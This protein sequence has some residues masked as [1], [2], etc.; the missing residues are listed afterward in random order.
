MT[1]LSYNYY[2]T[3]IRHAAARWDLGRRGMD[4]RPVRL[5]TGPRRDRSPAASQRPSHLPEDAARGL[6]GGAPHSSADLHDQRRPLRRPCGRSTGC[7]RSWRGCAIRT[8]AVPGTWSRPSPPSRPTRSRKP[9]RSPTPSSADDLTDLKDE[10]GDLLLQV[11]FHARMAEEQGAFAFDDVAAR[12]Q[13]QDDPPPS[14]RV[15]ATRPTPRWP[16]RRK[17]GRR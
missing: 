1:P 5:S 4:L 11:V 15:R 10:L 6:I 8:A 17:A 14:A 16:T 7:W 9:T 13:R 2:E 3:D 12:D